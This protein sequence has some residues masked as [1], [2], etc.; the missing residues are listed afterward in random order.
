MFICIYVAIGQKASTVAYCKDIKKH[1]AMEYT[2]VVASTAS[3]LSIHYSISHHM[4]D[5]QSVKT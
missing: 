4:Q 1:D 5:V 2:I 3:D